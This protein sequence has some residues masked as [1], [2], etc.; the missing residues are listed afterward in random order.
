MGGSGTGSDSRGRIKAATDGVLRIGSSD[1]SEAVRVQSRSGS[2]AFR[3][4]GGGALE[5]DLEV[6]MQQGVAFS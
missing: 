3:S 1:G 5:E 6:S 2:E 4:R